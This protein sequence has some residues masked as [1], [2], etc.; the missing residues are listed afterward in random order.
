MLG[1]FTMNTHSPWSLKRTDIY[2][3]NKC[4]T[5]MEI[6]CYY[7]LHLHYICYY[8]LSFHLLIFK[9]FVINHHLKKMLWDFKSKYVTKQGTDL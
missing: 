2:L 5:L 8:I 1:G 9:L 7:N 6:F 4:N 3:L